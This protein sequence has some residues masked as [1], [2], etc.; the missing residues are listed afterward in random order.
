MNK[1]KC[2]ILLKYIISSY[3]RT[4]ILAI[5][6]LL[7]IFIT[8]KVSGM[9]SMLDLKYDSPLISMPIF[10]SLFLSAIV[11]IFGIILYVYK[12]KRNIVKTKFSKSLENI[13]EDKNKKQ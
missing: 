12:Y 10:I 4:L 8:L 9:Y 13:F 2:I 6:F 11:F 7:I 3:I 5:P 1:S